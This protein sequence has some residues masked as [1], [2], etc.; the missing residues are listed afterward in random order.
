MPGASHFLFV[1]ATRDV[2][3]TE[4]LFEA[5][6]AARKRV[7]GGR[8]RDAARHGRAH[9]IPQ[10]NQAPP[11]TLRTQRSLQRACLDG[12][13]ELHLW[14]EKVRDLSPLRR[15]PGLTKLVLYQTGIFDLGPL[16]FTPLLREL[17]LYENPCVADLHPV[18]GLAHL[19]VLELEAPRRVRFARGC[20]RALARLQ[21]LES[22]Q[23]WSAPFARL[24][25]MS[26]LV[27]LRNLL[28]RRCRVR[29]E[30]VSGLGSLRA[31][32]L[33]GCHTRDLSP[34]AGLTKL[35]SLL[36][37][38]N[39]IDGVEPLRGLRDLEYLSLS[40][41][42]IADIGPLAALSKLLRLDAD[43]NRIASLPGL[44]KLRRLETLNLGHNRLTD[45]SRLRP[46]Q[47]LQYLTL[48]HNDLRDVSPLGDLPRLQHLHLSHNRIGDLRPLLCARSLSVVEVEGNPA[49]GAA[50]LGLPEIVRV[51]AMFKRDKG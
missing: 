3:F 43:H 34:L 40:H 30:W 6:D 21:T 14:T 27:G 41:N 50:L 31:L 8:A 1:P 46:L 45:V 38:Q 48:V 7:Y 15:A 33:R 17:H 9:M 4:D 11:L 20:L 24:D 32:D 16:S 22:L 49:D 10:E 36:L 44:S 42:A 47:R 29:A 39:G 37:A 26:A 35:Q 5:A 51:D 12:V 18:S 13:R 23:I 28:V 2:P 25:W 19:R